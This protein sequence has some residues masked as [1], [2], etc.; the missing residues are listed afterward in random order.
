MVFKDFYIAIG[1]PGAY[2]A[3]MTYNTIGVKETYGAY[4]KHAPYLLMQKSKE[5]I[6]Q[7]WLD[8]DGDDVYLPKSANGTPATKHEATDYPV[9]FAFHMSNR[10]E[11]GHFV[12]LANQ[13]I[14][15]LISAIKGRWLKIYDTYSGIGFDGVYLQ[16]VDPD[17]QFVRRKMDTC[18]FTLTFKING[19][20]LATPLTT[21]EEE[22]SSSESSP[23]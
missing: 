8:E 19:N 21:D 6:S 1:Q 15:S 5:A 7:S 14:S 10:D 9:V 18:I 17:P 23:S 12:E 13:K 22:E 20:Q 16:E 3:S 11:Y 4:V 2:S